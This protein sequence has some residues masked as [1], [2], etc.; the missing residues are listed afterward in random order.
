MT[1]PEKCG[2]GERFGKEYRAKN[3]ACVPCSY[4]SEIV[5]M[6]S[7]ENDGIFEAFSGLS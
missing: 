6:N 3:G 4:M 1:V 2:E 5:I 7:D